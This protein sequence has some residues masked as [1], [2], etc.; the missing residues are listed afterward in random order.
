MTDLPH[1]PEA[2]LPD[3]LLDEGAI[4]FARMRGPDADEFR[5]EFEQWCAGSTLH[6]AAYE[7]AG[8]IFAAG[9][10]L[11]AERNAQRVV[12]NDNR[13]SARH[14]TMRWL[15]AA[16]V[17][18]LGVAMVAMVLQQRSM[19][20]NGSVSGL[21]GTLRAEASDNRRF[22]GVREHAEPFRLS[23]GSLVTLRP[24]SV[25]ALSFSADRRELRLEKGEARFEVAHEVRP[26]VVE[27]GGGS[28]TARGTVF[29]VRIAGNREVFVE[30]VRGAIDVERPRQ[31]DGNRVPLS[32]LA[33]GES[34]KF[35]TAEHPPSPG[36]SAD[37]LVLAPGPT[38]Y[39]SPREFDRTPLASVL[40][41]T[42]AASGVTI[43]IADPGLEQMRVSGRFR[44]NDGHQVAE[45][46]AALFDLKIDETSP[47]E[48]TLRPAN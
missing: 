22:V 6:L 7:K 38:D 13:R 8:E 35:V 20:V 24:G 27:A 12:A 16:A 36:S 43:V 25:L 31:V 15:A 39:A 10:F 5:N 37:Q 32:R 48:V 2:R 23:D 3:T 45:R 11:A 30:L 17:V 1:A 21:E 46:L 9:R 28:V 18:G 14:G 29:D 33:A 19:G 4:W 34:L 40:A 42:R 47:S 41:E 44:V 26:F